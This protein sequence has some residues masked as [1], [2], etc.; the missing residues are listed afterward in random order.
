MRC[1]LLANPEAGEAAAFQSQLACSMMNQSDRLRK[2]ASELKRENPSLKSEIHKTVK[3]EM[4]ILLPVCLQGRKKPVFTD[5]QYSAGDL[6]WRTTSCLFYLAMF[7]EINAEH[8]SWKAANNLQDSLLSTPCVEE[9]R[10]SMADWREV[11]EMFVETIE[12]QS[13]GMNTVSTC[14][15][16]RFHT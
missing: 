3:T 5:K 4:D 8:A 15:L 2:C 13:P 7:Q 10:I 14:N 16:S 11:C 6:T 1:I 12:D 9:N